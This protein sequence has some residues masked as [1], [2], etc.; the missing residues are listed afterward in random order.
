MNDAFDSILQLLFGLL[1]GF[2]TS[3]L[4][5]MAPENAKTPV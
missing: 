5:V 2:I 1:N 3:A 4:F